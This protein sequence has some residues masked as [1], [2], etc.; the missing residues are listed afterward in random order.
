[1]NAP[2]TIHCA[3]DYRRA[4]AEI[5]RLTRQVADLTYERDHWKKEACLLVES[6]RIAE[7]QQA[8]GLTAPEALLCSALYQRR[9]KLVPAS[10]LEDLLDEA[11]GHSLESNIVS[12]MIGKI[13]DKLG[14]DAILTFRGR[15]YRLSDAMLEQFKSRLGSD[16]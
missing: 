3:G 8:F 9:D 11:R 16:G 5:A 13:R 2:T 14:E 10:T 4:E 12:V 7:V 6:D 1:M 15:G